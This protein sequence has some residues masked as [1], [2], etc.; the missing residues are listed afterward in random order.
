MLA[1][2]PSTAREASVA[3]KI[4]DR[5]DAP[6]RLKE[7]RAQQQRSMTKR[8]CVRGSSRMCNP[9]VENGCNRL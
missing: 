7:L 9:P 4:A 6:L 8:C 5:I 1:G 2:A 3:A